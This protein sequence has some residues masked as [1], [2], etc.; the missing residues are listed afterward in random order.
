MEQPAVARVHEPGVAP[1]DGEVHLEAAVRPARRSH[2]A[3]DRDGGDPVAVGR[4]EPPRG[5]DGG[6]PCRAAGLHHDDVDGAGEPGELGENTHV[7]DDGNDLDRDCRRG[8]SRKGDAAGHE[9]NH[10]DAGA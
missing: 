6:K 9:P 4:H 8:R 5:T 3:H 7:L 10:M 1:A 2:V